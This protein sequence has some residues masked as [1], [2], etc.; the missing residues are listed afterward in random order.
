M[1]DLDRL[2]LLWEEH[3]RAPS[4]H[5]RGV[6]VEGEDMVLLDADSAGCVSGSLSRSTT[7]ATRRGA[8]R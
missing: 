1:S 8:H 2:A 3:V 6:D 4:P 7:D 5:L